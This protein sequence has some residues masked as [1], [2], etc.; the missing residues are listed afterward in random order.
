MSTYAYKNLLEPQ[1]VGSG[2]AE[3]IL[4]APVSWF[5][6]IAT[7]TA[8]FT[9]QGDSITVTADHEFIDGKGFAK[10]QLAPRKNKFDLKSI[11]DIGL[12]KQVTDAI[13]IFVPGSY[14]EVH[15]QMRNLLN[16]PLIV[17]VKDCDCDFET[18]YQFGCDCQYSWATFDFSTGTTIDGNKGFMGKIIHDGG[19]FIYKGA[20]TLLT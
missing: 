2:I 3:F 4:L 16:T 20:I 14:A 13:E 19:L 15:E 17:L 18:Y 11:G 7:P 10:M 12:N 9:N 1:N 5:T 6:T 8:P